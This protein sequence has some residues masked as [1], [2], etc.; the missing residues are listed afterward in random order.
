MVF[1]P[2]LRKILVGSRYSYPSS[3]SGVSK[4][5]FLPPVFHSP[6]F[7]Y[8]CDPMQQ[9]EVNALLWIL[10]DYQILSRNFLS[11]HYQPRSLLLHTWWNYLQ[12]FVSVTQSTDARNVST[13]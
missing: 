8:S 3:K 13:I 6:I 11:L 5:A 7:Y 1:Q 10:K 4:S 2:L 9:V 12:D